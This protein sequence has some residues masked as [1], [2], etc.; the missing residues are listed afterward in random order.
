VGV[1]QRQRAGDRKSGGIPFIVV[2]SALCAAVLFAA[3]ASAD[4]GLQLSA[5]VGFGHFAAGAGS[6]R[7]AVVPT[8]SILLIGGEHWL[9]RCDDAVTLLGAAGGQF[10]VANTT[11]LSFG[12]R[13]SAFNAGAGV[14][15][16]EYS[17][18]LCGERW[19]ARVRGL[20]PGVDARV[21]AFLP[22]LLEGAV[23][24]SATCG[25]LWFVGGDSVWSGLSARCALGPI[26]RFP[27]R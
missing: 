22:G 5:S 19:C 18:P 27:S 24:L 2:L 15:L 13:W 3:P 7:F 1:L 20:A 11:T 17:L 6:P 26:V 16:S 8:A 23:G 10:G 12:A 25:M 9:F 21:D 14:S 4:P